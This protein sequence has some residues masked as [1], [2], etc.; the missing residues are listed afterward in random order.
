MKSSNTASKLTA[1]AALLSLFGGA[2]SP[3][4]SA[5]QAGSFAD[6]AFEKTWT[7][8]D[9]LVQTRAVSR[10]WYWG[11][12]ANTGALSEDYAEGP[13]GKHLVQ[14][15][16]KSRMEINN[17]NGDKN[18][19][20]YVTNGLLTRELISG[21]MQTGINRFELR[22]P[23]EIPVAGDTDVPRMV[24]PT[25]A[26]F[27][28]A[29]ERVDATATGRIVNAMIFPTGS[30]D[31]E[32]G[33]PYYMNFDRFNVRNAYFEHVTQHNIPDVFWQFLNMSGPVVVNGQRSTARLSDPYFYVTGY[34]I[35]DAYWTTVKIGAEPSVP[36]LIQAYERRVLTYVP[37]A[38]AGFKVQ[39]G[40]VGQ[41]YYDWR[42]RG[43]GKS[44]AVAGTCQQGNPV[45]GF[46][47]LYNEQPLLKIQLGCQQAPEQ[48]ATVSRQS[49]ESGEMIGIIG[50]DFYSGQNYENVFVLFR[51]GSAQTFRYSPSPVTPAAEQL[52][53]FVSTHNFALT[54]SSNPDVQARLGRPTASVV[55][56]VSGTQGGGGGITQ[57]F[58]GGLMVYPHPDTRRIYVLFNNSGYAYEAR[59]PH[60]TLTIVNRWA[61]YDD[62]FQP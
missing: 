7:R 27:R 56:A 16:D 44:P 19:P 28:G 3:T 35:S 36:V 1:A 62:R 12:Q 49:F 43:A 53:G 23:A 9:L 46:G 18:N 42:Y 34:P 55:V 60:L 48:R 37:S 10:S 33:G 47:K 2:I 4:R 20:F 24:A 5:A 21:N 8:T 13:G 25:Y 58:E 39:M 59:G 31:F 57:N 6:P 51:D 54:L 26:S 52:G 50:Y 11:P 38:P 30:L 14:Y 22:W 41:H 61:A 29:V 15:F 45:L 17:P 32:H 40:N